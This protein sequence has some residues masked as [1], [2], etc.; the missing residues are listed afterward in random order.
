VVDDLLI[1]PVLQHGDRETWN[2]GQNPTLKRGVNENR[3]T[4]PLTVKIRQRNFEMEHLDQITDP[5]SPQ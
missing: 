2:E 3:T 1:N 5:F 4:V